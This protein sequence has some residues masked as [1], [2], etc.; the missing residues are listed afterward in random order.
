VHTPGRVKN[1]DTADL[2]CDHYRRYRDDVALM[3]RLG[4]K[5]YRFSVAWSRVLPLGTG[6]VNAP[7]LAF[8]DRLTDELL[9]HGIE[10]VVTLYHWDLPAALHER[11]GWLNRD[12]AEWFAEY[13]RILFRKLDDRVKL[14][15][16]INEPWVI[17][18]GGYLHGALA[19]GHQALS[20][21][22]MVSHHLLCA[23]G[24]AVTAY[25]SEG[26][27]SIGLVVN[28]EPKHPSSGRAEDVAA[29]ER[30]NAY[31]NR[32]YLDPVF[33]GHYPSELAEI[34]GSAWPQWPERDFALIRQPIDFLGVNY[35]TRSVT[36][37]DHAA[38]PLKAAAVRQPASTYTEMDWEVYPRGLTDVLCWIRDRYGSVPLYVTENGAAFHDPPTVDGERLE[39]PLRVEYLR[40]HLRAVQAALEY[41]V[42]VRGYFVWSLL[43]NFEWVLGYSKRFGIVHVDF[44]SQRRTPKA[45]AEFYASVIASNGDSIEAR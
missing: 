8:Y 36:R 23:H 5:A 38:H 45:S 3:A 7:G 30:A 12:S 40:A 25:R 42:D 43:D 18:D 4:L 1:G 16:T 35:Y 37:F 28:I 29:A 31:M 19:P 27:H 15:A 6:A 44:D 21:A 11:G 13:A 22:P 39:D 9:S 26:K 14:W 33:L 41:Q 34:F 10:P 24:M 2:A 17:A 20:E 32:Q